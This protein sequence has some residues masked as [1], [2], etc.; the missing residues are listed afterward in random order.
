MSAISK[1]TVHLAGNTT[2]S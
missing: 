1:Y 2:V